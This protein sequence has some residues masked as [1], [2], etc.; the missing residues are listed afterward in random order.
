MALEHTAATQRPDTQKMEDPRRCRCQ[1]DSV[2]FRR[3]VSVFVLFGFLSTVCVADAN[4]L[5]GVIPGARVGA[6][7]HPPAGHP[8][9][10]PRLQHVALCSD[11]FQGALEAGKQRARD[12]LVGA[13]KFV[14]GACGGAA[15]TLTFVWLT[16]A[17]FMDRG[18]T[19]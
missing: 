10:L 18:Y 13:E 2:L 11:N 17:A 8:W 9:G 6:Y 16:H 5:G 15:G 3:V 14:F 4:F 7:L 19:H 12:I 1:G